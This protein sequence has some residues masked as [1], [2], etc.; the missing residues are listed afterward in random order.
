TRAV[1]ALDEVGG[2]RLEQLADQRIHGLEVLAHARLDVRVEA[3]ERAHLLLVHR[4][5]PARQLERRLPVLL[6]AHQDLVVDV[7]DVADVRDREPERAQAPNEQVR[8][9]GRAR[10]TRMRHVV[11]GGTAAV[12]ADPTGIPGDELFDAAGERVVQTNGHGLL[13][14][15][16]CAAT[17]RPAPPFY[18]T[19]TNAGSGT[20]RVNPRAAAAATRSNGPARCAA[21]PCGARAACRR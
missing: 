14:S 4:G 8:N 12:H 16:A 11:H 1:G 18:L 17:P 21:P 13:R 19:D 2:V 10:V 20:P 15:G 9:Q 7:R 3:P 6:R 5:H